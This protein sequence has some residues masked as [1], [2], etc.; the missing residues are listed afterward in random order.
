ML[1][2]NNVPLTK[3]NAG[4]LIIINM[5]LDH[6]GDSHINSSQRTLRVCTGDIFY[7]ISYDIDNEMICVICPD[8]LVDEFNSKNNFY[9]DEVVES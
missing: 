8:G 1:N 5:S 3:V 9:Q 7:V 2:T 4:D 6:L